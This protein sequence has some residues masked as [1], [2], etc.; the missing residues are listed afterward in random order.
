MDFTGLHQTYIGYIYS[1]F[2]ESGQWSI[3]DYVRGQTPPDSTRLHQTPTYLDYSQIL[4]S[5]GFSPADSLDSLLWTTL[6]FLF[7][8]TP[9]NS[10]GLNMWQYVTRLESGQVQRNPPESNWVQRNMWG[11]VKYCVKRHQ[12]FWIF[13]EQFLTW[14]QS[15]CDMWHWPKLGPDHRHCDLWLAESI[16][17]VQ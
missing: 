6:N 11:S 3:C 10:G 14:D 16:E 2:L 5:R 8:W 12:D 1:M 17:M 7:Q 15:Q 4:I 13:F 9:A